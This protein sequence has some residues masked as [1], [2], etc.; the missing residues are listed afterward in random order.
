MEELH[1]HAVALNNLGV[2]LLEQGASIQALE[3]FRDA[4]DT[5]RLA[6]AVTDHSCWQDSLYL[7]RR[8]ISE[9]SHKV[10]NPRPTGR[11]IVEESHCWE[12]LDLRSSSTL[13]MAS[14]TYGINCLVS[15]SLCDQIAIQD[16][17][18]ELDSCLIL[19]NFALAYLS[20]A[21]GRD[22]LQ[23]LRNALRLLK[24]SFTIL[25]SNLESDLKGCWYLEGESVTKV[26]TLVVAVLSNLSH[27]LFILGNEI[28]AHECYRTLREMYDSLT[29]VEEIYS[30]AKQSTAAAAA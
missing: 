14:C 23:A 17:D 4:V 15:F 19:Y 25:V 9:A 13:S 1:R 3:T 28:E 6:C 10:E 16:R 7:I 27:T 8:K 29:T 2:L 5:M 24:M 21:N 22:Q 30:F 18:R 26:L 11:K 12:N 20:H